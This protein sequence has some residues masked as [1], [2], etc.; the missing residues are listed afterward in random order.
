MDI[1]PS[2]LSIAQQAALRLLAKK[3]V[4][5][6]DTCYIF[7]FALQMH[8]SKYQ[9]CFAQRRTRKWFQA[10]ILL[11]YNDGQG[12]LCDIQH[13]SNAQNTEEHKFTTVVMGYEEA[14]QRLTAGDAFVCG[15]FRHG[16][17]LYSKKDKLPAQLGFVCYETLLQKTREGWYRWFNNSCQFMDCTIYCLMERNFGMAVFMVHQT[18]EQACKA[19]LKVMLHMRPGTHNLAWMLKLCSGIA[20]EIASIFP[21]NSPEERALFKLVKSSYNDY[22]Y[23]VG[24]TVTEEQAWTLYYRASSLLKI[25]GELSNQRI[26]EMKKWVAG[27]NAA[28]HF[29]PS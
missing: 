2:E 1:I 21:R 20:P 12:P 23:A 27:V 11:V 26:A 19:M 5:Q 10:D 6:I 24:F 14:L 25:A 16:A 15:V 13:F 28:T 9:H 4:T 18:I 3:L 7:C 8:E 17:L 22:R 29:L